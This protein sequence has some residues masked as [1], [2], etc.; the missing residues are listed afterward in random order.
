[1]KQR[2]LSFLLP[3]PAVQVKWRLEKMRREGGIKKKK[4]EAVWSDLLP[5]VLSS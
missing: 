1:M 3:A 2:W 5:V 4:K